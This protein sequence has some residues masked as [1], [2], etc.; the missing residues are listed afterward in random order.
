[1]SPINVNPDAYSA[2]LQ[3]VAPSNPTINTAAPANFAPTEA[4]KTPQQQQIQAHMAQFQQFMQFQQFQQFLQ[5]QQMQQAAQSQTSQTYRPSVQINIMPPTQ[6]SSPTPSHADMMPSPT[7]ISTA[8]STANASPDAVTQ[9]VYESRTQSAEKQIKPVPLPPVD[10]D[11]AEA[12]AYEHSFGSPTSLQES[13]VHIAKEKFVS[14]SPKK[15]PCASETPI[16]T[17]V[18]PV[19]VRPSPR[20]TSSLFDMRPSTPL[21]HARSITASPSPLKQSA[22][23]STSSLFAMAPIARSVTPV[24]SSKPQNIPVVP[25]PAPALPAA[26]DPVP[27]PVP[28]ADPKAKSVE[29]KTSVAKPSPVASS[30]P[31]VPEVKAG[32]YLSS[33]HIQPF[34]VS[35]PCDCAEVMHRSKSSMV[36]PHAVCAH[37]LMFFS[38]DAI[39]VSLLICSFS[40]T[41]SGSTPAVTCTCV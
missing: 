25:E 33:W 5:F 29:I 19:S 37:L 18:E 21:S 14:P 39:V 32:I 23:P 27:V 4:A 12:A 40:H 16:R 22:K 26:V 38:F 24:M 17:A 11:I 1:M 13:S 34:N 30:P 28:V 8:M 15:V 31:T 41:P 10:A 36:S 3:S 2:F 7:T 20:T 9:P 6:V 35:M